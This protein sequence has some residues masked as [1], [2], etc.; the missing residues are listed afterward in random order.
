MRGDDKDGR[1]SERADPFSPPFLFPIVQR[2]GNGVRFIGVEGANNDNKCVRNVLSRSQLRPA[3]I[4]AHPAGC[5]PNLLIPHFA[6]RTEH[7]I[8]NHSMAYLLKNGPSSVQLGFCGPTSYFYW[9][10]ISEDGKQ[11]PKNVCPG[12]MR[13]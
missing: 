4:R 11:G 8:N 6:F 12:R 2:P 10:A 3:A 9:H 7:T 1:E 5:L 13:A